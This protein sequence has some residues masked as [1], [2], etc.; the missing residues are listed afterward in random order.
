MSPCGRCLGKGSAAGKSTQVANPQTIR[1]HAERVRGT[2]GMAERGGGECATSG[3][4]AAPEALRAHSGTP[5]VFISYASQD[6]AVADAIVGALERAGLRCW[7]APRDVVPGALY[8]DEIVRAITEAKVVAVVLSQAAAASSHVRREIERASSKHRRIVALRTD[9]ALPP[10]AFEYFLSE[11]QWIDVGSGGIEAAAAKL[12]DAVRRHLAPMSAAARNV[13]LAPR[14]DRRV[15]TL[16]RRWVFLASAAVLALALAS[17][18]IDRFR[19]SKHVTVEQ[20]ALVGT[21]AASGKSIAVLPFTDM[22]EKKDQ[23]YFADGMAE[24]V[25]DLLMKVPDLKVIGRT[26][27]FQFK[28]HSEDLRTIGARLG[29]AYVV[30]GTVRKSGARVR[31]S[32]QLL[33]T[34]DGIRRWSETYERPFGDV[35]NLQDDI[36]VG[37]ARALE[38][39]V[40]SETLQSRAAIQNPEAYDLYLRGLHSADR[41]SRQG[42]EEAVNYF[43]QALDLD[44]TFAAAATALGWILVVQADFNLAPPRENYERARRNL[45]LAIKLDSA[46]GTAHAWLAWIHTAYD[47]DWTAAAAEANQ[48]LR[49]SPRDSQV[50]VAAARLSEALGHWDEAIGRINLALARDPLYPGA[51]NNLSGVYARA[52][53]LAEAELAERR[54]LEISP[55]YASGRFR[56]ANILLA[57]GRASE[58]LAVMEQAS[59][60]RAEALIPIYYELGRKADSDAALAELTREHALDDAYSIAQA[61]AFRREYDE[62][63]QWLDRAYAQKDSGLYLVK[64]ELLL[65]KL[66]T[67]PRYEAFLRKM[68]LPE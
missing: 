31:V 33:S 61:H 8:A 63:F 50:L 13:A 59:A 44:P 40:G 4:A 54:T 23:E 20:Q 24:E 38:L 29:A 2:M 43:Q 34:R 9:A 22:S 36:A 27:S 58:A 6:A 7:I 11:S 12:V 60:F 30:E 65:K 52:G 48:A 66:E 47:W 57:R 42:F 51:Q 41:Y 18:V 17:F 49:L 64:G 21:A 35:L 56:L 68:G 62:A 46:S 67:D 45:E 3:E 16:Q 15:A 37:V 14:L 26:S 39:T 53:R 5:D 1:D 25:L 32:A 19:V 10:R 55:T 28:G